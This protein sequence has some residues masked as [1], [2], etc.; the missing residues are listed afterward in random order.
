[1]HTI[2]KGQVEVCLGTGF[3]QKKPVP[4][5]KLTAFVYCKYCQNMVVL[6]SNKRQSGNRTN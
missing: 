4:K 6:I 1:M 5:Q 2:Q 3:F